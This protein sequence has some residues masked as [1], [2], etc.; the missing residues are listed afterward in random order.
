MQADKTKKKSKRQLIGELSTELRDLDLAIAPL[1]I[2][3]NTLREFELSSD[4]PQES[5]RELTYA[6]VRREIRQN[7]IFRRYKSSPSDLLEEPV[8]IIVARAKAHRSQ[9]S[10]TKARM[11]ESI[12][13]YHVRKAFRNAAF[14]FLIPIV[15]GISIPSAVVYFTSKKEVEAYK[16]QQAFL[17]NYGMAKELVSK[18]SEIQ[19]EAQKLQG[20]I[21]YQEFKE[22]RVPLSSAQHFQRRGNALRLCCMNRPSP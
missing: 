15:I 18:L 14:K 20:D 19:V 8:E 1:D 5:L 4:L 9:L 21:F 16:E 17:A 11:E 22:G 12:F 13:G 7:P 10:I 2:L 3:V 6:E